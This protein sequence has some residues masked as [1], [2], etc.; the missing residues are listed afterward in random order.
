MYGFYI[1]LGIFLATFLGERLCKRRYLDVQI[2][3]RAVFYMLVFGLLGARLYHVVHRIEYFAVNPLEI[4]AFWQGGLGIWG[5]LFGGLVGF[6]LSVRKKASIKVTWS[7]LDV[8]AVCA[9]LAQAVGRWGNYFNKELFGFPT[10]LPWGLYIPPEF[11]SEA[12]KYFDHF[13]PL[14]L[15]ESVLNFLLF[16]FLYSIFSPQKSAGKKIPPGCVALL[17]LAG[18]SVIRF[19]LEFLRPNPWKIL[20]F[21]VASLTSI[22]T[23]LVALYLLS[24]LIKSLLTSNKGMGTKH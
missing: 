13:H 21:P 4:I 6:Y 23:F 9:P 20:G 16:I 14:F 18:Y 8:F 10:I 11:R 22:V 3:W 19:F 24:I 17:Y 15:Y 5:G 2:F 1:F 7:Y 12:F